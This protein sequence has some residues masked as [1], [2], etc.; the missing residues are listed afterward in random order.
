MST[1][2]Q[3]YIHV[4]HFMSMV[5]LA[6]SPFCFPLC[7][8]SIPL[9]NEPPFFTYLGI[10]FW[11]SWCECPSTLVSGWW[12]TAHPL[13]P[14]LPLPSQQLPQFML[15]VFRDDITTSVTLS[16]TII[17]AIISFTIAQEKDWWIDKK[18]VRHWDSEH[19]VD[20]EACLSGAEDLD[21]YP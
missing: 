1:H 7:P 3:R 6:N 9:C 21:H 16:D 10:P 2:E 18:R 12:S 13:L 14:A 19:Q 20:D 11:W 4:Q 5:L 15:H 17:L 8:L